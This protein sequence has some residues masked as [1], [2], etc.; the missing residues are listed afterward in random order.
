MSFV[1]SWMRA[2]PW[3]FISTQS[4]TF[5]FI[6][7]HLL[8]SMDPYLR[9]AL[10]HID[11]IIQCDLFEMDDVPEVPAH[12]DLAASHSRMGNMQSIGLRLECHNLRFE[13]GLLKTKTLRNKR[14]SLS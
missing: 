2:A 10:H 9:I 5:A 12:N 1:S 8:W 6:V 11:C 13:V 4:K 14:L 7:D 3:R